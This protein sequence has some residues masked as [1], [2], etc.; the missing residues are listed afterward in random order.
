MR[1]AQ[2]R[3]SEAIRNGASP[4][5]IQRLMDELRQATDD[6]IRMLAENMQPQD[7][8]GTDER[9]MAENQGQ[10]ITGDQIQQMMDE[11]QRLMEEGRMAEA[12]ELLD[13]L[14]RMLENLQVT[15]GEG[16]EGMQGP[17]GQAMR[18]LQDTLRQQQ[19]LSDEAFGDLQEQFNPGGGGERQRPGENQG[20]EQ[21]QNQGQDGQQG[22]GQDGEGQGDDRSLADRQEAL[23]DQLRRQSQGPLPGQGTEEGRAAREALDQAGRAMEEAEEALRD[24]D[25]GRAIDRQAEAIEN[26]REG[27]RGLGDAIARENGDQTGQQGEAFG[28]AGREMPRDPLGRSMGSDGRIGTDENMLQGEDVYRRAEELL[29]EIRRR[30]GEQTRPETERDYLRRLLDSF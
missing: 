6:Y 28:E 27:L 21:G 2:E 1:Q 4:E 15:Q 16:G 25:L 20:Q 10:Q 9:D 17:G 18:N 22:E 19:G 29:G 30:S 24:G 13:Q 12:Q 5:E 8:D 11:I 7:G 3:L 14:S 23:R 26:L